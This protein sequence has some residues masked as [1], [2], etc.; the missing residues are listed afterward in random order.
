MQKLLKFDNFCILQEENASIIVDR[1]TGIIS[2]AD[3]TVKSYNRGNCTVD[4]FCGFFFVCFYIASRISTDINVIHHPEEY[5]MTAVGQ[6]LFQ[7]QLHS[8]Q[9]TACFTHWFSRNCLNEFSSPGFC[10]ADS[11]A[12]ST[13]SIPTVMPRDGLAFFQTSGSVQSSVS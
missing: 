3:R 1:S 6:P 11:Q 10:L 7:C 8:I 9:R 5:W 13:L 2:T 12:A 4:F